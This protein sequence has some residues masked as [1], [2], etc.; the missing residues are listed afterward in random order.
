MNLH[1]QISKAIVKITKSKYLNQDA[2]DDLRPNHC[3]YVEIH[4][5]AAQFYYTL[6]KSGNGVHRCRWT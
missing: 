3:H 1:N 6:H 2:G 5:F 4:Q